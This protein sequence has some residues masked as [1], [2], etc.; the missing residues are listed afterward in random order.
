M[1][2]GKIGSC[3]SPEKQTT[4]DLAVVNFQ[5]YGPKLMNVIF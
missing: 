1:I 2:F 5:G 4:L 3:L